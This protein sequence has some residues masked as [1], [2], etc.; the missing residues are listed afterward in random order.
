MNIAA[1]L[2]DMCKE[3]P[4]VAQ[5]FGPRYRYYTG[6]KTGRRYVWTTDKV[7][8]GSRRRYQAGCT[9]PRG[10]KLLASRTKFFR[11]RAEAEHYACDLYNLYEVGVVTHTH[12]DWQT[13]TKQAG[14]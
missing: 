11:T 3:Y 14:G 6:R 8:H 1:I 10:K 7:Q 5:L 2:E 4:E 12:A 13:R 9:Q